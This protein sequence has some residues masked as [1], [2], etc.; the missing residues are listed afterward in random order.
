ME[1]AQKKASTK[2]KICRKTAKSDVKTAKKPVLVE[3]MAADNSSQETTQPQKKNRHGDPA[4]FGDKSHRW[5][6]EEALA[7]A[8]KGGTMK[9]VRAA[10]MNDFA[11]AAAQEGR[12]S[13]MFARAIE[14]Q[15]PLLLTMA[16]RAARMVGA[17]FDQ[18]EDAKQKVE[19]SG[20][21]DTSL[22]I[23]ITEA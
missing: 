6:A 1:T 23:T 18:S 19:L 2:S 14:T 5:S 9:G 16:E 17:T 4:R 8:K 21:V 3:K 15:D 11:R 22:E 10:I 20:Q 12:L 7:A 13:Q